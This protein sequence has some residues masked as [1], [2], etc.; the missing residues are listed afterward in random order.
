MVVQAGGKDGQKGLHRVGHVVVG[1]K[2]AGTTRSGT[3]GY[4]TKT[5]ARM[6][7]TSGS[8]MAGTIGKTKAKTSATR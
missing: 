4:I 2:K 7:G 6:T 8:T 1:T 3:S 5:V